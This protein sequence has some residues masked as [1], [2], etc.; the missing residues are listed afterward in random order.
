[1][2]V[3][4]RLYR[5]AFAHAE[6]GMAVLSA[7]G[8]WLAVNASL[9]R[10]LQRPAEAL[11][12]TRAHEALF[13]AASAQRIASAT[14]APREARQAFEATGAD[15]GDRAWKLTLAPLGDHNGAILLQLEDHREALV[16]RRSEDA[17][18]RLQDHLAYGISHDLRAPLR[19]IAGFATKLDESGAVGG[20]EGRSDLGRI[21][22]AAA[23]AERLIDG[24]LELLRAA[25][26]PLREE[27]VDISLL[28]DWV[29]AEL[30]DADPARAAV[31]EVAPDLYAMGDEHWLKSLLH[32]LFDNAWKFSAQRERVE[33]TVAGEIAGDRLRLSIRD[34]GRGFD[35]RYAD[36]LFLPFQRLHGAEQGSGNG[37]GLAIAQQIAIR[38]GGAMHAH[39]QPGE[40]STFFVELPAAA[41]HTP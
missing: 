32:K 16:Q 3:E 29:A 4:A 26:Q 34:H 11:V 36:K 23:R 33:I 28:C 7:Q 5:D 41:A 27:V 14:A 39:S 1:M 20:D 37:L 13:D 2:E 6:A 19:S 10:L 12:G 24:L 8:D 38:H 22:A 35:M 30:R 25:R 21:R 17:T 15:D 40:G 31:V 18:A 9:C